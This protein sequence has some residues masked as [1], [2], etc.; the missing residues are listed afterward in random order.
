MKIWERSSEWGERTSVSRHPTLN[1][2]AIPSLQSYRCFLCWETVWKLHSH[3]NVFWYN[4]IYFLM[5]FYILKEFLPTPPSLYSFLAFT[6]AIT[7]TTINDCFL[8]PD[9][10]F[11]RLPFTHLSQST[12]KV[13]SSHKETFSHFLLQVHISQT[14]FSPKKDQTDIQTDHFKIIQR[15]QPKHKDSLTD[16]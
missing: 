4:Q 8:L 7:S 10:H 12:S 11:P 15:I 1:T 13:H 16:Y 9:C 14:T 6:S 3:T 5:C 2:Q